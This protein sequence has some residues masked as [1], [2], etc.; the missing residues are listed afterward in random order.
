LVLT[1]A[2]TIT[3][4]ECALRIGWGEVAG[5]EVC[6]SEIGIHANAAMTP[7]FI[8]GYP[9]FILIEIHGE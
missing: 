4:V 2:G 6:A 5:V 9:V 3:K 8:V 7:G 1:R